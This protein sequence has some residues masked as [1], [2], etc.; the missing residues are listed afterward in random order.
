[1]LNPIYDCTLVRQRRGGN[2]HIFD[3]DGLA[4]FSQICENIFFKFRKRQYQRLL[5]WF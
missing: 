3:A 2:H 4:G 1:M 5:C